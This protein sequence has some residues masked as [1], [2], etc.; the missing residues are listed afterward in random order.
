MT[1][2][3]DVWGLFV[4]QQKTSVISLAANHKLASKDCWVCQNVHQMTQ[5]YVRVIYAVENDK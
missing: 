2:L 1:W 3:E 4:K 5:I